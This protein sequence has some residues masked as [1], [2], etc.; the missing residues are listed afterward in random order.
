MFYHPHFYPG[1][2][3]TRNMTNSPEE[4]VN[5]NGADRRASMKVGKG[6]FL[7]K[8]RIGTGERGEESAS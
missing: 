6:L 5:H 1:E 3:G 4:D 8:Y 7:Q 2:T